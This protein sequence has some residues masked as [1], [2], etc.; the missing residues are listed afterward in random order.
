MTIL[1]LMPCVE[2]FVQL[3]QNCGTPNMAS[4][5]TARNPTVSTKR[6]EVTKQYIAITP[7][8][9]KQNM[10]WT[11][12]KKSVHCQKSRRKFISRKV[13]FFDVVAIS[14]LFFTV[15]HKC[16]ISIIMNNMKT[17]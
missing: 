4:T 16:N 3:R 7:K 14:V 9:P 17:L 5:K 10:N 15:T 13:R 8:H 6:T 11:Y 2:P 1:T 12:D